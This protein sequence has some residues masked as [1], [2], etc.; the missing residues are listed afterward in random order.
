MRQIARSQHTG[1][2]PVHIGDCHIW[3]EIYY[4]DSP[5]DYREFLP[6]QHVQSGSGDHELVMSDSTTSWWSKN[7]FFIC[8]LVLAVLALLTSGRVRSF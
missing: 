1:G 8:L 4:L 7:G 2:T 6:G 5:T 3:A